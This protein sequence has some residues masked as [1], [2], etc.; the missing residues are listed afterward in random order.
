ML[1]VDEC[2]K[3]VIQKEMTFDTKKN[4]SYLKPVIVRPNRLRNGQRTDGR[5]IDPFDQDNELEL[6]T[7]SLLLC[8]S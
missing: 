3:N 5:M 1:V 8:S 4:S 7:S 6:L 2:H